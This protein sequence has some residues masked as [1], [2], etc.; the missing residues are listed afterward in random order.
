ML[1]LSKGED[2]D[3]ILAL[4]NIDFGT[5]HL[6]TDSNK[7]GDGPVQPTVSNGSK[8]TTLLPSLPINL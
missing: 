6:Y 5:V 7:P 1:K 4:K 8:T 2:Y 3:A